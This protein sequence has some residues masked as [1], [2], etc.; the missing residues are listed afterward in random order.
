MKE[1]NITILGYEDLK[2]FKINKA[3]PSTKVYISSNLDWFDT[4]IEVDF[5]GQSASLQEIQKALAVKQN[6]VPLEDGSYGLLPDEWLQKFSLLFKMADA[7]GKK[8]RVSKFN[9]SVIDDMHD[10]IDDEEIKKS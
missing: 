9:F 2:N 7:N 4:E 10:L 8:L 5:E 3:K 1:E 6:Y